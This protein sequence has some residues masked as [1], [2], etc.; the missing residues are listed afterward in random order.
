MNGA[1]RTTLVKQFQAW[2]KSVF[3]TD[4]HQ[5]HPLTRDEWELH[6]NRLTLKFSSF[7]FCWRPCQHLT[8]HDTDAIVEE[9]GKYLRAAVPMTFLE[10][11]GREP[12]QDEIESE[13]QYFHW[14]VCEW[15]AGRRLAAADN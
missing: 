6:L 15:T 8:P 1:E 12:T 11:D 3:L 2:L 13:S 5:G 7:L 14:P 10:H 9:Y 4:E